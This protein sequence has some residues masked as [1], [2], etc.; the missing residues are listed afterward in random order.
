MIRGRALMKAEAWRLAERRNKRRELELA[1]S[2]R[3]LSV[4]PVSM[5]GRVAHG[6]HDSYNFI[7]CLVCPPDLAP[8][9]KQPL[10]C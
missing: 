10:I 4:Q 3:F 1:A 6:L 2:A 8:C 7:T 5:L 9:D